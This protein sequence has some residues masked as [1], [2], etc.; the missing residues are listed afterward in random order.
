MDGSIEMDENEDV[1]MDDAVA[2]AVVVVVASI[3]IAFDDSFVLVSTC[4]MNLV[5]SEYF[6]RIASVD[7]VRTN[8]DYI[9]LNPSYPSSSSDSNRH[10]MDVGMVAI[11]VAA[12]VAGID[13]NPMTS[14]DSYYSVQGIVPCRYSYSDRNCWMASNPKNFV[15]DSLDHYQHA[16]VAVACKH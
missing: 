16:A 6:V 8:L 5:H 15:G 10:S 1:E 2:A 4:P 12:V 3:G 14:M 11:G 13:I 7:G 9:D